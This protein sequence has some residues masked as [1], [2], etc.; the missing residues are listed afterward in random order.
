MAEHVI[1]MPAAGAGPARRATRRGTVRWYSSEKG[2]GF[3]ACGDVGEDVFVRY[4]DIAMDGFK[5]L[6]E[7]QR[8]L[9]V[10]GDDGRGP[11]ALAVQPLG[12]LS[13]RRSG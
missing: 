8:V 12:L 3:I 2:Y 6:S 7:G 9:F 1:T 13:P 11:V 5:A 4:T 10:L